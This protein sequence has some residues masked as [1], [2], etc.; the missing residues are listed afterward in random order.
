MK[1]GIPLDSPELEME[2]KWLYECILARV[3]TKDN[4][5]LIEYLAEEKY[6]KQEVYLSILASFENYFANDESLSPEL[7]TLF[8]EMIKESAL[9]VAQELNVA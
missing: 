4:D 8:A 1:H 6:F 3:V 9:L 2:A 7:K 5:V